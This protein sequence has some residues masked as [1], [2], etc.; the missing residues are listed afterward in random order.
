LSKFSAA[1]GA[2]SWTSSIRDP[3]EERRVYVRR[4]QLPQG[5]EGLF[6][7]RDI[8]HKEIIALYNGIKVSFNSNPYCLNHNHTHRQEGHQAQGDHCALQWDQGIF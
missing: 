3:W 6:A 4:S 7:K 2:K 8:K 1:N 5:G